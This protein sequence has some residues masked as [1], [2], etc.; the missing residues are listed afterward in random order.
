M[1]IGIDFRLA[2][3]STRGMARYCREIVT[4][5]LRVDSENKYILYIDKS[6]SIE[7]NSSNYIYSIIE[8]ENY[9][10]GE[11]IYL[12]KHI[13]KD[14]CHIFWSPY[15]TFPINIP[16]TTK[17]FVTIHDVIFL[18][19]LSN[20]QSL[21]QKIGALYRKYLLT[22]YYKKINTC[23]TVSNYSKSELLR[24]IP[25]AIP[26]NITY[27]CISSFSR[28]VEEYKLENPQIQTLNYFFTL[29]GDA[30][31]KNLSTLIDVF[32]T[33]FMNQTIVIGGVSQS[34]PIRARKSKQVIFLDEGISD[35]ELIKVYLQCKCF[36]FCSKFEGF[37]I[38]IIEAAICNKPIIASNS[39]SIPEIL[40]G[41]GILVDPTH[42]GIKA[43]IIQ[44][45]NGLEEYNVD[46]RDVIESYLDWS[47]PAAII[48]HN[49]NSI[50]DNQKK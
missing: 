50:K 37:G 39:T 21:R 32:E 22:H 48:L 7:F 40:K 36:L 27:N 6:P 9:I 35:E 30:P 43:G 16:K 25:F 42:Q 14:Q 23:F 31:S 4:E 3:K 13:R 28:K 38:P 26:I 33:D 8:S 1:I 45:L 29:S 24:F 5:L 34:S 17:L 2:N 20:V 46:Y 44:Y 47:I 19:N 12:P 49:V 15:N 18:Y 41:K 10:I 11:Q